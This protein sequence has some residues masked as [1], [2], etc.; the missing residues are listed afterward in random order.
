MNVIAENVNTV[1]F[2]GFAPDDIFCQGTAGRGTAGT[3]VKSRKFI[4]EFFDLFHLGDAL[5]HGITNPEN[6]FIFNR[7]MPSKLHFLGNIFA[8]GSGHRKIFVQTFD[9]GLWQHKDSL[10]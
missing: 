1:V 10:H 7:C 5:K 4:A 6:R 9:L 2:L 8:V 3:T